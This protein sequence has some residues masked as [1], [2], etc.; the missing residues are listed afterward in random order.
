MGDYWGY[1]RFV[2]H[3]DSDGFL[4]KRRANPCKYFKDSMVPILACAIYG[5]II[6]TDDFSNGLL[7]HY[8]AN[9]YKELNTISKMHS[10]HFG[11]QRIVTRLSL[12]MRPF[13][14][15]IAGRTVNITTRFSRYNFHIFKTL[16]LYLGI[17]GL[18]YLFAV[19][20]Q[21]A[22]VVAGVSVAASI[23]LVVFSINY[24]ETPYLS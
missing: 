24:M 14:L 6:L 18:F 16:P 5:A 7:R 15:T 17:L 11:M 13:R 19:L 21:K 1:Y 2:R 12:F 9:G 3:F 10:L 20:I 22:V 8:I 23:L 4:S